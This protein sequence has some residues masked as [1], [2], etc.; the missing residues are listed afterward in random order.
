MLACCGSYTVHALSADTVYAGLESRYGE[1]CW[2]SLAISVGKGGSFDT[3][4]QVLVATPIVH[5]A[6]VGTRKR[7]IP[8]KGT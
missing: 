4:M 2:S 1:S 7:S 6:S 3:G 8:E 5:P